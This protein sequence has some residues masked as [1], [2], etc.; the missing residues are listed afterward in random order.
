MLAEKFCAGHGTEEEA[1]ELRDLLHDDSEALDAYIRF[2]DLHAMLATNAEM[3]A[4]GRVITAD[5]SASA[6]P[7]WQFWMSY[8]AAVMLATGAAF[9]WWGGDRTGDEGGALVAAVVSDQSPDALWSGANAPSGTGHAVPAGRYRLAQGS[10]RLRL[11]N[12]VDLLLTGPVDLELRS[13]DYGVLHRGRLAARVPPQAIGF[14]VDAGNLRVVDLG[15]EFGLVMD[16]EQ[17][18]G[19]HVFEGKVEASVADGRTTAWLELNGGQT[20]RL[21]HRQ[22]ALEP[23]SFEPVS[24]PQLPAEAGMPQTTGNVRY[25]HTPPASLDAGVFEHDYILVLPERQNFAL[26]RGLN[27]AASEPGEY[28]RPGV[29]RLPPTRLYQGTRVCSYLAHYDRPRHGAASHSTGSI[30]FDRPILGVITG[31]RALAESDVLLGNPA[32][33]YEPSP[34]RV[35]E[36]SGPSEI[37]DSF[38]VS[39]DRR[40]LSLRWHITAHVDELRILVAASEQVPGDR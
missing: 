5:F 3:A 23:M 36:L 8:A 15:T 13:S 2:T 24:F 25:L 40:T 39:A 19:V 14:R 6:R 21:D 10:A 20:A 16:N 18:P 11:D 9:W 38:T 12:G 32:T 27:V 17:R 35:L 28:P 33:A 34:Q 7:R 4:P 37:V 26:P 1:A 30:T 29:P 31:G 22:A